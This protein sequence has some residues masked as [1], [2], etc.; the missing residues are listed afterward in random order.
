MKSV[1]LV[2]GSRGL[3]AALRVELA[4]FA[5]VHWTVRD[6]SAGVVQPKF[7][8]DLSA[9]ESVEAFVPQLCR[10]SFDTVIFC[11]AVT[12]AG[13]SSETELLGGP[14][15]PAMFQRVMQVNCFAPLRIAQLL[16][17]QGRLGSPGKLF[18][19]SSRAGSIGLRGELPHHRTGG[20]ALYR[21]S[22]AALNC[23]VRNLALDLVG[24]GITAVA[25]H[26]G[27]IRTNQNTQHAA[28]ST[29]TAA[30]ELVSLMS[31]VS[32]ED[33]G[34]FLDRHGDEIPW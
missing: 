14:L 17:E 23:G 8:L 20:P 12:D 2:G 27:W 5:Q 32:H 16:V 22:K 4:S 1:L 3:G 13:V 7:F 28:T 31:R 19:M 33:T 25:L 11:A 26:P 6:Q 15:D 9:A 21:I 34:R 30:K 10:S 29:T 18:F 24:L